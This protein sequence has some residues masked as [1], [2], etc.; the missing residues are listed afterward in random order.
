MRRVRC[1]VGPLRQ[2]DSLSLGEL[3]PR[4]PDAPEQLLLFKSAAV[5]DWPRPA[6]NRATVIS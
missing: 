5:P 1:P 4:A 3:A 2:C 6:K